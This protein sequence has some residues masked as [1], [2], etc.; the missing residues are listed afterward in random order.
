MTLDINQFEFKTFD[1]SDS[2]LKPIESNMKSDL[3]SV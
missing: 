1:E 2:D 3:K